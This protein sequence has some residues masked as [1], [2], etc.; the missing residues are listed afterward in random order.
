MEAQK[1][2]LPLI[3]ILSYLPIILGL[4]WFSMVVGEM[5][6][7]PPEGVIDNGYP[8][9]FGFWLIVQF[10]LSFSAS[11]LIVSSYK[12]GKCTKIFKRLTLIIFWFP[13]IGYGLIILISAINGII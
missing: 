1:K 9:V 12:K 13:F 8:Y 6:F 4:I 2:K 7:G 5:I 3:T 10:I 11:V